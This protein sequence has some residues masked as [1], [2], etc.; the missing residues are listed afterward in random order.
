MKRR[1]HLPAL[2]VCLLG[3]VLSACGGAQPAAPQASAPTAEAPGQRGAGLTKFTAGD[4]VA[5]QSADGKTWRECRLTESGYSNGAAKYTITGPGGIRDYDHSEKDVPES[6][7]ISLDEAKAKGYLGAVASQ[8]TVAPAVAP[9]VAPAIAPT[10][11]PAIA[12]TVAPAVAPTVAPAAQS[13]AAGKYTQTK[14]AVLACQSADGK[15][16]RQCRIM[17]Y[18]YGSGQ[19][20]VYTITGLGGEYDY[21]NKEENV[22]ESRILPLD[23]ANAKG[24]L[25]AVASQPTV[26]PAIAPTVAPAIAPTVAPAIAPTVAPAIAPTVAPAAQSNPQPVAQSNLIIPANFSVPTTCKNMNSLADSFQGIGTQ[27]KAGNL[28]GFTCGSASSKAINQVSAYP[29]DWISG[30]TQVFTAVAIAGAGTITIT[31][32]DQNNK[33]LQTS[34]SGQSM[35]VSYQAAPG[36]IDTEYTAKVTYDGPNSMIL[37]GIFAKD[38][39]PTVD[40]S[41]TDTKMVPI[42]SKAT[43]DEIEQLLATLNAARTGRPPLVWDDKLAEYAQGWSSS[44]ERFGTNARDV[45]DLGAHNVLKTGKPTCYAQNYAASYGI[46]GAEVIGT[47]KGWLDEEEFWNPD[48]KKCKGNQHA[49]IPGECG[50]Y[51]QVV[52]GWVTKIGCGYSGSPGG[53]INEKGWVCNF[54][55]YGTIKGSDGTYPDITKSQP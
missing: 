50:H 42:P 20:T 7:L 43:P 30:G 40:L 2:I 12:P 34:A 4:I 17:G 15:T 14:G 38:V 22:A 27:N 48:T 44:L 41:C 1:F 13:P 52:A 25:G 31:L 45:L 32:I 16:W 9:T 54:D 3:L 53:D 8:P 28:A 26:A 21:N 18:S 35:S 6:R 19:P 33:V 29:G 24:Y 10:V 5:C 37:L 39:G 11:A 51:V 49:G 55:K 23:E 46:N 47:P 36:D